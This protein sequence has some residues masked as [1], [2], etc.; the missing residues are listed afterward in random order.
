MEIKTSLAL[1]FDTEPTEFPPEDY[2]KGEVIFLTEKPELE[3]EIQLEIMKIAT[4]STKS[5]AKSFSFVSSAI[6]IMTTGLM[7]W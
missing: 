6:L 3:E 4:S 1:S 2:S 7:N 5:S